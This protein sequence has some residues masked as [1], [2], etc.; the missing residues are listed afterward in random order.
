MNEV[1]NKDLGG[2]E[3]L[4]HLL[5][6]TVNTMLSPSGPNKQALIK[7]AIINLLNAGEWGDLYW[8][9]QDTYIVGGWK[10]MCKCL[11]FMCGCTRGRKLVESGER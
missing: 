4:S 11:G 2:D 3:A 9:P 6:T 10:C 5:E 8:I 1:F 7:D